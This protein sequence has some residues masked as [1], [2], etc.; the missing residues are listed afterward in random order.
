MQLIWLEEENTWRDDYLCTENQNHE[1]LYTYPAKDM[2]VCARFVSRKLLI[3]LAYIRMYKLQNVNI[4]IYVRWRSV[5]HNGILRTQRKQ[6]QQQM[7]SLWQINWIY[8]LKFICLV[9]SWMM[10]FGLTWIYGSIY[11]STLCTFPL[12]RSDVNKW[13]PLYT[14]RSSN[15]SVGGGGGGG[16]QWCYTPIYM[17]VIM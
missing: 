9:K 12:Y 15:L 17:L 8:S 1:L 4:S 16:C 13:L 10:G 6:L 5:V 2:I 11:R 3:I 7:K 14:W